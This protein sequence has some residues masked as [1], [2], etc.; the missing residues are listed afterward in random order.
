VTT[1]RTP[2]IIRVANPDLLDYESEE[3]R[4]FTFQVSAM[5]GKLKK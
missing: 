5:Q 3:G 1:F 4:F 2:V